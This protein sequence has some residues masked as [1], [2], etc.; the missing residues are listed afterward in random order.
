MEHAMQSR[1]R[2]ALLVLVLFGWGTGSALAQANPPPEAN[3]PPSP[4]GQY[5]SNEVVDAGDR[6]FGPISRGPA[7]RRAKTRSPWGT[8]QRLYPGAGSRRRGG[9]RSALWGGHSVHQECGRPAG[10]L[11]GPIA[12]LRF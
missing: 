1:M 7:P 6:F 3:P 5:S 4:G 8:A 11:A 12:R 9:R 10:L 2:T